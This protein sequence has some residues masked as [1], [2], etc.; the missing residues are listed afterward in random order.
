MDLVKAIHELSQHKKQLDAAIATLESLLDGVPVKT[1]KK[2]G[3]KQMSAEERRI[4]SARMSKYWASRR[5]ERT[6]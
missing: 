1:G 4:V 5:K 3:R 6:G 2:R